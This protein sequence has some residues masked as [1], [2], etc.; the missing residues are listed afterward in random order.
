ME[1]NDLELEKTEIE[2]WELDE[3]AKKEIESLFDEELTVD[4]RLKL[5]QVIY[6]KTISKK[7]GDLDLTLSCMRF[8]R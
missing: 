3:Y 4:Q 5:V 7:I 2:D 8:D 6:L 1:L